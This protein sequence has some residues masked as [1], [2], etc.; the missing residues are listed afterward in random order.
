MDTVFVTSHNKRNLSSGR[1]GPLAEIF[2][3]TNAKSDEV[4]KSDPLQTLDRLDLF[5]R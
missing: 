5:H 1:G 2:E 3:T 4:E